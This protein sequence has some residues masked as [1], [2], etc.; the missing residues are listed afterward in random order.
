MKT[1]VCILLIAFGFVDNAFGQEKSECTEMEFLS[2]SVKSLNNVTYLNFTV[3]ETDDECYYLI[4]ASADNIVY[5]Q[6]AVKRGAKSVGGEPLLFSVKDSDLSH[7]F[8]RV[9]RISLTSSEIS[10]TIQLPAEDFSK[11]RK[12]QI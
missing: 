5:N 12:G 4:E 7:K 6:I 3:N 1:I 10:S 9:R 11:P 8:F 2:I